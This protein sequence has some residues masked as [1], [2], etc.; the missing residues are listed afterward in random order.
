M[1]SHFSLGKPYPSSNELALHQMN[2]DV[3]PALLGPGGTVELLELPS[4]THFHAEAELAFVIGR[5]AKNVS[6][7]E[8]MNYIFG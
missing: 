3:G 7:E 6:P 5:T 4:V 1:V 2:L 8:A